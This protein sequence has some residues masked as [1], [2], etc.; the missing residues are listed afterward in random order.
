MRPSRRGF[1][2]DH[3]KKRKANLRSAI[4][5]CK[6]NDFMRK[7]RNRLAHTFTYLAILGFDNSLHWK[8][9][10]F[11]SW[12]DAYACAVWCSWCTLEWLGYPY[13]L[14][15]ARAI[16]SRERICVTSCYL[17]TKMPSALLVAVGWLQ[18]TRYPRFRRGTFAYGVTTSP[19]QRGKEEVRSFHVNAH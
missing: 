6:D 14:V 13:A 4:V 2:Q 1:P 15:I 19:I 17:T 8:C 12:C 16:E 7:L 18:H 3:Y 10:T 11:Q 5:S 9:N